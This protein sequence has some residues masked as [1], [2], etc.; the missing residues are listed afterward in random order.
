MTR[1]IDSHITAEELRKFARAEISVYQLMHISEDE[2][3]ED[4][5]YTFESYE[6]TLEDFETAL[7]NFK[8]HDEEWVDDWIDGA[9]DADSPI[10]KALHVLDVRKASK[11]DKNGGA[12]LPVT[13]TDSFSWIIGDMI[14]LDEAS[15]RALFEDGVPDDE[16]ESAYD[17]IDDYLELIQDVRENQNKPESEWNFPATFMNVYIGQAKDLI[18]DRKK[19]S[20]H[21]MQWYVS[22]LEKLAEN[23]EENAIRTLIVGYITGNSI[24][25]QDYAKAWKWFEQELDQMDN[26]K[27]AVYFG[28]MAEEGKT[29]DGKP[30]LKKAFELYSLASA[31]GVL[32]GKLRLADMYMTGSGVIMCQHA[33]M[34][35]LHE[36]L[37]ESFK[38][39]LYNPKDFCFSEAA[40]RLGVNYR[41][42]ADSASDPTAV[43]TMALAYFLEANYSFRSTDERMFHGRSE[44]CAMLKEQVAEAMEICGYKYDGRKKYTCEYPFYL[45][46]MLTYF[47]LKLH[48]EDMGNDRI[49]L[50]FSAVETRTEDS[51]H[52]L[53]TVIPELGY[54]T[55][56]EE[57]HV[58]VDHAELRSR[59]TRELIVDDMKPAEGMKPGAVFYSYG[60]EV[61]KIKGG[62]FTISLNPNDFFG[63]VSKKKYRK[64]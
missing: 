9:L 62:E 16:L 49:D 15:F 12:V 61:L 30:D 45:S 38:H 23:G 4:S 59:K 58:H 17:C 21:Q 24:F 32:V 11:V 57:I 5:E 42:I 44:A 1:Q 55:M 19:L 28:E 3:F 20:S 54:C 48:L 63:K 36:I 7:H 33:A 27:D 13:D 35:L 51:S 14:S 6:M 52:G 26:P 18:D 29:P 2:Y 46:R 41:D 39:F 25:K 22:F 31:C 53:M 60:K 64:F 50:I 40:F 34:T 8:K 47:P 43:N 37:P 10:Q 56:S